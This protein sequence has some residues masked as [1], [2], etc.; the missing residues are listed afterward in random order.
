MENTIPYVFISSTV[1]EFRD[2]RSAIAYTLRTQ[3]SNV[4]QSEAAG[5]DVKGD[6]SSFEECFTNVRNSDFYILIIG[7]TRGSLFQEGISVTRQEYRIA[8]E[9]FLAQGR[10]RLLMYLRDTTELALSGNKQAR[11]KAGIDDADHLTSFIQEVKSPG[12]E[13]APNYL[14][15]FR[16]FEDLMTSLAGSMNLGRNLSEKLIRH[17]LLSELL[18]NLTHIVSGTNTVLFPKHWYMRTV[19]E[20]ISITPDD[21][22][23]NINITDKQS[24]RLGM[25]LIGRLD[26]A[27]LQTRCIEDA[28]DRGVFL[29]F[30]PVTSVLEETSIHKLLLQL[31]TDINLL[32]MRD[33]PKTRGNWS[34]D[35]MKAIYEFTHKHIPSLQIRGIDLAFAF[36]HYDTTEDI[37]QGHLALCKVLLG[38]SDVLPPY[39]RQP[40]TPFG[41]EMDKELRAEQVSGT[42]IATLIQNNIHPFGDKYS[43][44]HF[45]KNREET[46]KHLAE[47]FRRGEEK[48]GVDMSLLE[49]ADD[50]FERIADS[51][52]SND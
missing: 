22:H 32:R 6:R 23:R 12:I 45:G 15:H 34:E 10:P 8:R 5:F 9:T 13:G 50:I 1:T 4:Y 14:I 29:T 46:V 51:L 44:V 19:R 39:Q 42:Q 52:V 38:V 40:L 16:D 21:I 26:G 3:G 48:R 49:G 18:S 20:G 47:I 43:S 25:S 31:I 37:F 36:T 2:L 30:N 28:I 17:S 35:I 11:L 41:K 24:I 7:N 27:S 33:M